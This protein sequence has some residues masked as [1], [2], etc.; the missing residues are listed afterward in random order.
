MCYIG[1]SNEQSENKT[2]NT[3]TSGIASKR[4]KYL[5]IDLTK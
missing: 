5:R 1:I 3:I 4:K 2:E